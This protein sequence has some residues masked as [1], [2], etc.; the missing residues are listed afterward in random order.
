MVLT[1]ATPIFYPESI[2]PDA[3]TGLLKFNPMYHFIQ[4]FRKIILEGISPQPREYLICTCISCAFLAAG[5]W[6]FR[7]LQDKFI[8]YI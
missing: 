3:W 6:I 1:Y 4:F 8:F 7:K 2:L 5:I